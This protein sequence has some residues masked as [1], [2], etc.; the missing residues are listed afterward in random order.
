MDD[1]DQDF[2]EL[3]SKPLKRVRKKAAESRPTRKAEQHQSCSQEGEG[4]KRRRN[5][6]R[7]GDNDSKATGSQ[8][9]CTG[10]SQQMVSGGTGHT[11]AGDAGS[12]AV[13]SA[14]GPGP[15]AERGLTAKDKVLSRMQQFKRASPQRMVHR[16]NN[17][18][19]AKPKE[20]HRVPLSQPLRQGEMLS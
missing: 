2:V 17:S 4:D 1:S 20:D 18:Q 11:A 9:V 15:A 6:R 10:A 13:L 5:N 19:P 8:S 7:N 3:C 16:S 12:L 14:A